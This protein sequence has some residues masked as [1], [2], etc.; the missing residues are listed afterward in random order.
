LPPFPTR[1][2][3]DLDPDR[4]DR[5]HRTTRRRQAGLDRAPAHWRQPMIFEGCAQNA[6]L[7]DATLLELI[8][9]KADRN[10]T[11]LNVHLELTYRCNE[12]CVHCY[13]VVEPGREQEVRRHELTLDEIRR[14]LDE[15]AD[16]GALYLTLSGGG[17][18]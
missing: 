9:A 17:V 5:V 12:Q 18:S 11:P 2:S 16:M 4:R 6:G 10:R 8:S 7:G 14:L 13:C 3:S 1:R 15:L